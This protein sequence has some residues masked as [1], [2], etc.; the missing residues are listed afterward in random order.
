[1][2]VSVLDSGAVDR[3]LEPWSEQTRLIQWYLLLLH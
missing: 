1:M 2:M 3:G